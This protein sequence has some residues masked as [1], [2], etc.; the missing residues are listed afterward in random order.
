ML[1]YQWDHQAQVK[2]V[3]D[4]LTKLGVKVWMDISGGMSSDIYESMAA[5]VSNASAVVCFMSQKYQESENCMLEVKF[6]K[7]SGVGMIP[8]MME[9]GGWRPSGWLG[10]IT[11]GAL[12]VR[13]SD[14]SQ[15]EDSVRQLHGQ[16]HKPANARSEARAQ[17]TRERCV[18]SYAN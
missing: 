6:A 1:S 17:V 7:Q 12:W 11:A 3:Y 5:G 9:G 14:E 13:L 4:T 8:V 18:T 15:F 10:L 2:R 16:L